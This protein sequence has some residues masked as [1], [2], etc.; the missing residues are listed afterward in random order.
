MSLKLWT[1]R[2]ESDFILLEKQGFYTAD[3]QFVLPE[4]KDAYQ[5]MSY[6]LAQKTPAPAGID[7]PVWA[8]QQAQG[9][10]RSKPDLRYGGYLEKGVRGV[11]IEFMIPEEQVLLSDFDGWHAVL[12]NFC[13]SLDDAEYDYHERLENELSASEFEQIKQQSWLRI[14]DLDLLP[15]DKCIGLGCLH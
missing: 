2:P 4:W 8:W 14:F 9:N 1:V 6:H 11:R 5:W 10:K 15:A 7:V 13:F 3:S 12:N